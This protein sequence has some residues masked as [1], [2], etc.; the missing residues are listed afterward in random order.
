[1]SFLL[2][3]SASFPSCV[4][5]VARGRSALWLELKREVLHLHK[6][7]TRW[8]GFSCCRIKK[9][10]IQF[11]EILCSV[12]LLPLLHLCKEY[13]RARPCPCTWDIFSPITVVVSLCDAPALFSLSG[14]L[15]SFGWLDVC[16]FVWE[17]GLVGCERNIERGQKSEGVC[18]GLLM[19]N[20]FRGCVLWWLIL[21]KVEWASAASGRKNA[22]LCIL[23][24][25]AAA[26]LR[27]DLRAAPRE[28]ASPRT[29]TTHILSGASLA[30]EE[31]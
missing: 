1:M 19:Q 9:T 31:H 10:K 18:P 2:F 3:C 16:V 27:A 22:E 20:D 24:Q 5:V 29:A 15:M 7:T 21:G 28:P 23:L 13:Q 17:G 25:A 12:S 8:P 26:A 4:F 6:A 11:N 14:G 30:Q